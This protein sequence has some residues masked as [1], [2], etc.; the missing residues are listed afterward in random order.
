MYTAKWKNQPE[1]A[2]YDILEKANCRDRKKING[3]KGLEVGEGWIGGAQET[4]LRQWNY[5]AWYLMVDTYA[6]VKTHRL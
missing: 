3:Y 6:L 5:S 1:K 2:T 4:F